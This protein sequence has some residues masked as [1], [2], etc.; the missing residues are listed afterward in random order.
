MH[1]W[2]RK[3]G[4]RSKKLQNKNNNKFLAILNNEIQHDKMEIYK[5]R[6]KNLDYMLL[7]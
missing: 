4:L 1:A 2:D 3:K 5:D 7:V 6:I